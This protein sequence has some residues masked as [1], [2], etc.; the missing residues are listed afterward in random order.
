MV[1]LPGPSLSILGRGEGKGG[2]EVGR[3][4]HKEAAR[5]AG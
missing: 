1:V 5:G 4:E 2:N 3:E